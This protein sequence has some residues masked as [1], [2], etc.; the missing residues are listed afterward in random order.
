VAVALLGWFRLAEPF[1]GDNAHDHYLVIAKRLLVEG[2]FNGPDSRPDSKV[3]VGYPALLAAVKGVLPG[4]YLWVVVG[5]QMTAD[6]L[7]ACW[8]YRLARSRL[9]PA[10]GVLAGLTW[11]LFPPALVFSTWVTAESL[12]T[13]LL[14]LSVC[15]LI[16]ALERQA[17]AGA[18]AAGLTLGVATL[19]RGTCIWLPV[20]FLP[21]W[22]LR[23]WSRHLLLGLAFTGG[24]AAVVGPWAVRN[25]VVL[26]DS[27]LVSV[28]AG[29]AFLQGSDE[30]VFTIAGK[31]AHYPAMIAAAK[32][33]G[34]TRPAGEHESAIDNF[35]L[36]VG[37]H[38]YAV[39]WRE[40][41]WTFV[42]FGL[43]KLVRMWYGTESGDLLP[44]AGLALM[45]VL[46]VP[47]GLWQIWRWRVGRPLLAWV[48]GLVV[49]Y[50]IGLHEAVLPQYRYL[51][52]I[53]PLL[54]LGASQAVLGWFDHGRVARLR[55]SALARTARQSP[56]PQII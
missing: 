45:A 14:V 5:I 37:L 4:Y 48:F 21:L 2:R 49:L 6:L 13:A 15:L 38:N 46:V 24:L 29:S 7:V 1:L 56:S 18:L 42:P 9:T 50:F 25:R 17:P 28:G 20:F 52:P 8:L 55:R 35:M 53:Y 23:G 34:V 36:R 11:L 44:E 40:H 22:L 43:H 16:G 47:L 41:P 33:A 51:H 30:H 27:I 26:G 12:F 54:I 19:F 39:R 31:R 32:R 10:A 3:P